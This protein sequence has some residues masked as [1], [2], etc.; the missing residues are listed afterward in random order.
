MG[1]EV[2]ACVAQP[3]AAIAHSSCFPIRWAPTCT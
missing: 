2:C 1:L 3:R